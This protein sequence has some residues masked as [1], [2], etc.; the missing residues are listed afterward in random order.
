[1]W[2]KQD[3]WEAKRRECGSNRAPGKLKGENVAQ[4]GLLGG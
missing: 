2:L 1:M 3:S 4:T